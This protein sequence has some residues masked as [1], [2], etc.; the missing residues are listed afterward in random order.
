MSEDGMSDGFE[1]PAMEI[2]IKTLMGTTFDIKVSSMDT[3]E[4]IKKKIYRIEGI[5]IYQQSL[6]FQSREMKDSLRLG[7]VGIRQGS[8][9]TLI[10]LMRGGPISTRRLSVACEHHVMLKELKEILENTREEISP[11]SKVSVL[12]FKEGDVINLLRVIE[13]EDGSYSPYSEKPI[14]PPAKPSRK[15]SRM[16]LFEKLV[17]DNEMSNKLANLRQKMDEVHIRKTNSSKKNANKSSAG[18]DDTLNGSSCSSSSSSSGASCSS[19]KSNNSK[20]L[21]FK[22]LSQCDTDLLDNVDLK[23]FEREENEEEIALKDKHRSNLHK[24]A[25]TKMK[26]LYSESKGAYSH[27]KQSYARMHKKSRDIH[28]LPSSLSAAGSALAEDEDEN[29]VGGDCA[30]LGA[31]FEEDVAFGET[32]VAGAA[33]ASAAAPNRIH[34]ARLVLAEAA[35]DRQT[36]SPNSIELEENA[37]EVWEIHESAGDRL[38]R[39][40]TC[41][42]G[43][44]KRRQSLEY[45]FEAGIENPAAGTAAT[46]CESSSEFRVCS[47]NLYHHHRVPQLAG[48]AG[49]TTAGGCGGGGRGRGSGSQEHHAA[50]LCDYYFAKQERSPLYGR[51]GGGKG[52]SEKDDRRA[53]FVGEEESSSIKNSFLSDCSGIQRLKN[54]SATDCDGIFSVH[55]QNIDELYGYYNLGCSADLLGERLLDTPV[56]REKKLE[57][58]PPVI[59]KKARC[60]ECNKRL[61]IT[62][63]YDCRCGKIFC[64]QHR[65]SEVHRC[66]YDYKLEGRKILEKQNPL[67]TAEKISRI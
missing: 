60:N 28:T 44:L 59:K 65:Y 10:T 64:S 35:A 36:G 21:A 37:Q 57:E 31:A 7:D 45:G 13:N 15:E 38:K 53:G 50:G 34:L 29:D 66:S 1:E 25:K 32:T 42:L 62:N 22:F 67:V 58:L 49:T 26:S 33:S 2:Q 20:L 6:I 56:K 23:I 47:G 55:D 14:S 11:G 24:L 27:T 41:K 8:T 63:I 5:P 18:D 61:N 19:S 40:A 52:E 54:D 51:G 48:A 30:S 9:L 43:L 39:S 17:E 4:D 3:I 12:V 46:A 16:D